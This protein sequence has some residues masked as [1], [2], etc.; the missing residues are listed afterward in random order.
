MPINEVRNTVLAIANK[1]NYGYI[2]PADFN[3]YAQQAQMDMFEDYFYQYNNQILKE[4]QRQSGTGY[5]DIS[6]GLVEVIDTF[7]VNTPLLNSATTQLGDIRTNL[8][9]LPSDYYLI[10]KMMVYTKELAAG[11]TTAISGGSVVVTDATA[12]FIAAGVQVGDIASTVTNGVVYNTVVSSILSATSLL[13]FSTTGATVWDAIGKTYNIYS[14][15][16]IVEAERVAQSKITMLNNSILTKPNISYPAYTQNAL[17]AEAFPITI[18]TIG[19]VTTQYVRYPL[20]PNWTYASLLAGEPL[21]DPTNADYQDFELPLS[22]EPT[23]IA[24]ICQYVG[25]EIREADVYNFGTQELQQE[26]QTQ[27]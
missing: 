10:N 21:F 9:T 4:N 17:V 15:N 27:G 3:L 1:N 5:A 7:Y 20:T 18:N 2:S 16:D 6:K 25:I 12:D 26:Q 13:V 23:L 8:Y 14:A 24:K 22:D 11:I 19:Q